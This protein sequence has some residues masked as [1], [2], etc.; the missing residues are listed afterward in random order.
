MIN[1]NLGDLLTRY[2]KIVKITTK[3]SCFF[4][5]YDHNIKLLKNTTH[6]YL[7]PKHGS[8]NIKL[9]ESISIV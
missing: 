2:A 1:E 3:K 8:L 6:D 5:S 7:N 4:V 9:L